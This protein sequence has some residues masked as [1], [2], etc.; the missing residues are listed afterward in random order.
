MAEEKEKK[1]SFPMLPIAHW[2]QLRK[3][4]KKSIPGAVTDNYV[5]TVLGMQPNSARANVL[6][7]LEDLRIIGED[8]R[9]TE[10]ATLWRDDEHYADVCKAI[11]KEVYPQELL[12][13]VSDPNT[14]RVQAERWFANHTG[15]GEAAVKRMAGLYA[16][17]AEADASKQPDLEKKEAK[18]RPTRER[19]AKER[20]SSRPPTA[21]VPASAPDPN[22]YSREREK[23]EREKEQSRRAA[24]GI[25]INLQV[26]ISADA[27]PDQIDQ[28][29]A[30]MAKHIYPRD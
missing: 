3:Q 21:S 20:P 18:E 19:P 26:H 24:P 10:R 6:P 27:T 5:A 15:A 28:I 8:N 2:W 30:S 29:F 23:Q 22:T 16:V 25:N 1:K 11:L 4:F 14:N 12:D 9:P 17:L 7:F 13:A